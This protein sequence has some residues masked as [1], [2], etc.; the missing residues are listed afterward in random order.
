MASRC[1]GGSADRQFPAFLPRWS[2]LP[3][4]AATRRAKPAR[5]LA[6]VVGAPA[7]AFEAFAVA[8]RPDSG[9]RARNRASE[10]SSFL[11]IVSL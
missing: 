9:V 1:V 10:P 6:A 4:P 2:S 8:A 7:A 11:T 5:G 3:F